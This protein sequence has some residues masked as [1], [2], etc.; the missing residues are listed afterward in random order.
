MSVIIGLILVAS[1]LFALG[2]GVVLLIRLGEFLIGYYG[3]IIFVVP[4]VVSM[5]LIGIAFL[6]L[7]IRR[8]SKK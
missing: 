5:T 7:I 3:A 6:C 2:C 8:L 1:L 4:F